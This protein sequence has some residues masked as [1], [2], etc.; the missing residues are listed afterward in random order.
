MERVLLLY[1]SENSGHHQATKAIEEALYLGNPQ[2]EVL[3]INS[4]NYTNPIL[5]RIINNLYNKVIKNK[6]EV[7]KYL[8][9]NPKIVRRTRRLRKV[10][11]KFNSKK[12][13]K[14]IDDFNPEAIVC[15]QAFPCGMIADLKKTNKIDVPLIGVLTDYAPHSYWMYGDVDAYVV[16]SEQTKKRFIDNG[17]KPE[18]IFPYGIPI[19]PK[20]SEACEKN[21][22]A[23]TLGIEEDLPTVLMMGGGQGLGPIEELIFAAN[24]IDKPFQIIVVC[25]LNGK[26]KKWLEKRKLLFRK[27]MIILGYTTQVEMLMDAADLIVSKPGGLTTAEALTKALP[28]VVV[29]PIPGQEAMNTEFLL[30]EGVAVKARN[31]LNAAML[32]EELL[33]E[34]ERLQ[35]MKEAALKH[36][37]PNSARNIV[38]LID[39]FVQQKIVSK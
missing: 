38:E 20:F 34:P 30:E 19:S 9:D 2:I 37:Q 35:K 33:N 21:M 22:V 11:H 39:S 8:Y 23:K 29:N 14:L 17:I 13:E 24:T 31:P 7:W 32:I 28:I 4:F 10:I 36:A 12:L 3:N 5:E 25:G 26:L 16:P 1:I 18:R 15:T 27:K 6:P